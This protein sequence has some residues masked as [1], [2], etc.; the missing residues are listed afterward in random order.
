MILQTF[1][2]CVSFVNCVK[3]IGGTVIVGQVADHVTFFGDQILVREVRQRVGMMV[4]C[5]KS[6]LSILGVGV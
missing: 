2:R 4:K 3:E 5:A 1:I 6:C